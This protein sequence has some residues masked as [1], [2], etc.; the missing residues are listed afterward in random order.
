MHSRNGTAHVCLS[1]CRRW[2]RSRCIFIAVQVSPKAFAAGAKEQEAGEMSLQGTAIEAPAT[3]TPTMAELKGLY[4][5]SMIRFHKHSNNYIEI[6]RCLL[7]LYGD[8]DTAA[9]DKEG[10]GGGERAAEAYALL[11]QIV[12]CAPAP[13]V[14]RLDGCGPCSGD[15]SDSYSCAC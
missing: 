11:K 13:V 12:W 1:L 6:V 10:G 15:H 7:A 8:A 4:Y 2:C 9:R 5:R 14:A 3:G